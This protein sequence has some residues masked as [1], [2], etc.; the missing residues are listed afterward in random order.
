MADELGCIHNLILPIGTQVVTRAAGRSADGNA[1]Y[2]IGAVAVVVAT[3]HEGAEGYRVRFPDG[4]EALVL[5][6]ELAIRKHV[7]RQAFEQPSANELFDYVIYRCVVGSRAYGLDEDGSDTDRRG[8]YLPPADLHWS[9]GG[10]PEQLEDKS[11]EE[12]Y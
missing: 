1:A 10:V 2:P 9:L 4:G 5:R 11:N 6:N 12:C 7:Q 3:P 8:I